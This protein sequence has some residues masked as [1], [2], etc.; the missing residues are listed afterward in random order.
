MG[1]L[2]GY[3]MRTLNAPGHRRVM[4]ADGSHLLMGFHAPANSAEHFAAERALDYEFYLGRAV[5]VVID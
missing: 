4:I 5:A 3:G 2:L 1:E